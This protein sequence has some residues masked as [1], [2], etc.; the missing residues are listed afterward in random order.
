MLFA[1]LLGVGALVVGGPI[2]FLA[3]IAGV[4][5]VV[6]TFL[7]VVG[8][9]ALLAVGLDHGV[10]PGALGREG[11]GE[12]GVILGATGSLIVAVLA[13]VV[14]Q[15]D[16]GAE[17]PIPLRIA[18]AALPFAVL[19]GLQWP[20]VVR[21]VTA[22]VLIAP[23]AVVMVSRSL[24]AAR[25]DR[26]VREDRAAQLA[27]EVGTTARPWV[28]DLDG[29][30]AWVPEATGSGLIWSP[31]GPMDGS[32]DQLFRLFRDD[33]STV[34]PD[35]DPC[36]QSSW[37]TPEGNRST[38]SCRPTGEGRW[39]R[40]SDLWQQLL[41]RRGEEWVGVAALRDVPETLLEEAM[42]SA[43]RMTDEE[44]DLWAQAMLPQDRGPS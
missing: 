35:G 27:A 12:R 16:L 21:R 18:P 29:F 25:E 37:S 11:S 23:V 31:Y 42:A 43:R 40:T 30:Q 15:R 6:V 14:I 32:G 39:R 24:D 4:G 5:P 1:G 10:G 36:A 34:A 8:L 7:L 38:T 17:L 19:A 41:E 3:L 20:G 44:Y 22:L 2:V 13:W 9:V 28:T 33:G 26:L